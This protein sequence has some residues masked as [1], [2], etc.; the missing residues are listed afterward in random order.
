MKKTKTKLYYKQ[1]TKLVENKTKFLV[2]QATLKDPH[3]AKVFYNPVMQFSRSISSA[4][5]QIATQKLE[6]KLQLLDGYT[7][8]AIRGMR[9]AKEIKNIKHTT[10]VD[11]NDDAIPYINANLK[12]NKLVKKSTVIH[13]DINK[14]I[15]NSER[16]DIIE[17]D[18]FGTPVFALENAIRRTNKRAILSITA[19]DMANLCGA[20]AEACLRL[21]DAK[22]H[23]CA[24]CHELAIRILIGKIARICAQ[25]DKH[26]TPVASW[27]D[28]HYCK[29]ICI[30]E[31]H[32]PKTNQM[33]NTQIGYANYCAQCL[34]RGLTAAPTKCQCGNS[35][36]AGK[37]W[38]GLL[39]DAHTLREATKLVEGEEKEF[40]QE[41]LNENHFTGL[42]YQLHELTRKTKKEMP[43]FETFL[44][45]LRNAGY[46]A[47]KSHYA[48]IA[49]KT[50]ATLKEIEQLL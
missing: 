30:V 10:Y 45:K 11:A 37:L 48:P 42:H 29:T 19:T 46:D 47:V 32:V 7:G 40:L 17:L 22:A 26:I 50:N 49:F 34:F 12:L 16:F 24:I 21:Y 13:D 36:Y 4:V 14:A 23:N 25:Y 28:G 27:F 5:L 33:L 2:P 44:A 20:N 38:T 35:G 31:R 41:L 8:L 9:Y 18:P 43:K 15:T 3:H 6:G 1:N 39:G